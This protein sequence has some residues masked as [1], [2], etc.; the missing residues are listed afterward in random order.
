M[1]MYTQREYCPS[2]I[3]LLPYS[4]PTV[5]PTLTLVLIAVLSL[6]GTLSALCTLLLKKTS[7]SCKLLQKEQV[8][9]YALAVSAFWYNHIT[10][11]QDVL[12]NDYNHM[13][14]VS[15]VKCTD[16]IYQNQEYFFQSRELE[17]TSD[18]RNLGQRSNIYMLPQSKIH[19]RLCL[20]GLVNNT[21]ATVDFFI[22]DDENDFMEYQGKRTDG[23]KSSIYHLQFVVTTTE[24][25]NTIEFVATS[26]HFYYF[27][28]QTDKPVLYQFNTTGSIIFFNIS[29]YE[30]TCTMIDAEKCSISLGGGIPQDSKTCVLIYTHPLPPYL[31]D[32]TT[33]H[34]TV[35]VSKRFEVATFSVIPFTVLIILVFS[36]VVVERYRCVHLC[37]HHYDGYASLN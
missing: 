27:V 8:V 31:V 30:E 23:I 4:L 3:V 36:I 22:F 1:Y 18:V 10:I 21:V 2:S 29:D 9:T 12:E 26:P 25:C 35:S 13:L 16:L 6:I 20:K 15:K 33:T 24:S 11:S 37:H 28:G 14:T 17:A 19:Y 34:V 32:P 7:Y 5:C